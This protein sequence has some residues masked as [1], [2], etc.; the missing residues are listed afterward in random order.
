MNVNALTAKI[1]V[2][3][4]E[5]NSFTSA[6]LEDSIARLMCLMQ[7]AASSTIGVILN[8]SGSEVFRCVKNSLE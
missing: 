7:D 1:L 5:I 8:E 3:N 4:Q 6:M 2:Q